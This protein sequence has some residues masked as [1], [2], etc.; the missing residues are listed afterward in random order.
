MQRAGP[1]GSFRWE[2]ARESF[3]EGENVIV[4]ISI[5]KEL[6]FHEMFFFPT[7]IKKW[8]KPDSRESTKVR[9]ENLVIVQV[10][11]KFFST[12]E[13]VVVKHAFLYP[14]RH[15]SPISLIPSIIAAV[16]FSPCRSMFCSE[17]TIAAKS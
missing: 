5:C 7:S 16:T 1:L 6:N 8:R 10:D 9:S 15:S 13:L 14:G 11:G 3:A 12:I 2:G 17:M 4:A